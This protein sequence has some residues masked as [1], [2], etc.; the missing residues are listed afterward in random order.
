MADKEHPAARAGRYVR[1]A[2]IVLG[3]EIDRRAAA[4]PATAPRPAAPPSPPPPVST[5]SPA[6]KLSFWAF[7]LSLVVLGLT[8]LHFDTLVPGRAQTILRLVLAGLLGTEAFLL[9]TNW[10]K[11][12]ER[13]GQRLLT[14]MWGPRGPMTRRE[15]FAARLVRDVLT[16]LG[17]AFLAAAVYQLLVA[18]V[19]T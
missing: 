17:I 2:G 11:A 4:A 15:K 16:L 10:H 12:N 14:R 6:G 9:T 1:A 19:G 5:T 8:I 3:K 13:V 18:L 7:T